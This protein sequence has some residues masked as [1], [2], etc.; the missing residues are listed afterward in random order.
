MDNNWKLP[1]YERKTRD[2]RI[3]WLTESIRILQ[4]RIA[5][6]ENEIKHYTHEINEFSN[7]L[8]VLTK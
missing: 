3:E 7:E 5:R 6:A 8:S 1:K 2:R 4:E